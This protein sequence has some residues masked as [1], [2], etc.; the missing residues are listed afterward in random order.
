LLCATS[1]NKVPTGTHNSG[2]PKLQFVRD[3]KSIAEDDLEWMYS[4]ETSMFDY[5]KSDYDL[6][7]GIQH[8]IEILPI[9]SKVS[10][11]KGHQ[12]RHK[13]RTKLS[14]QAK[15]NCIADDVC[16]ETHHQHPSEVG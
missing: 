6:L 2:S 14:L 8:K 11:V 5:L 7:Q 3:N 13:S 15:A 10:W 1:P 9:A 12:D 16:T 4:Q